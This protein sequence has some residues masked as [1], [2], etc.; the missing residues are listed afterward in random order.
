MRPNIRVSKKQ[1]LST[2]AGLALALVLALPYL[3]FGQQIRQMQTVG[4]L[5]LAAACAVSNSSVLLP[6]SSTVIVTAA[7]LTLDPALCVLFGGVGSALGEQT[8][9]LCGRLGAGG[10]G[11]GRDGAAPKVVV[12]L[13]RHTF[14]T[15]FLFA[16]IPLPVFDV[17]GL[18]AGAVKVSWPKFALAA[19]LGKMLRYAIVL[20]G[21]FWVLPVL[22]PRLGLPGADLIPSL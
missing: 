21:V 20:A 19:L 5:G 11:Y 6:T 7:A 9:Y 14:L 16:L 3:C 18:A 12:W 15:V 10:A 2:A 13:H 22:L 17:V 8:A 1:L 4:Y